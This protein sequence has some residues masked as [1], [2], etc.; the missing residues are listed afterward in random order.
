[1]SFICL[2]TPA[3]LPPPPPSAFTTPAEDP[4]ENELLQQLVPAL[5]GVAPRVVIG[6]KGVVWADVRGLNAESLT[7]DL[8]AVYRDKGVEKVRAAISIVPI[9]AEI[10]ALYG[11]SAGSQNGPEQRGLITILPGS[12]RDFLAHYPIGVLEPSLALSTLLDGIGIE[13]CADL[14]RLNLESIEVRF[15]AEGARLWRLSRADDSRRIFTT[16]PRALP[17]ASLDWVDYTLK[18]PERLVFIINAL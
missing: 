4:P 17:S 8:V 2:W 3:A 7:R 14:A 15:G 11:K 6:S 1:M 18:D 13:Y 16:V 9:C 10:A 5:L 12:E